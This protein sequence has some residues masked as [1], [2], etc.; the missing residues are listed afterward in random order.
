MKIL[1]L[2]ILLGLNNCGS[3]SDCVEIHPNGIQKRNYSEDEN[4]FHE[5]HSKKQKP[6]NDSHESATLNSNV[7]E[8]KV[9]NKLISELLATLIYY[10]SGIDQL[11]RVFVSTVKE[12]KFGI[13]S[14]KQTVLIPV[15]KRSP[16][17][18]LTLIVVATEI[19][20]NREEMLKCEYEISRSREEIKLSKKPKKTF[21]NKYKIET[22]SENC[23]FCRSKLFVAAKNVSYKSIILQ[24]KRIIGQ[25]SIEHPNALMILSMFQSIFELKDFYN[26]NLKTNFHKY[27][28]QPPKFD[29]KLKVY[30]LDYCLDQDHESYF[31]YW[32]FDWIFYFV[33]RNAANEPL[34][35]NLSSL[36]PN[37]PVVKTMILIYSAIV[38]ET[39]ITGKLDDET[40]LSNW[41]NSLSTL[42]SQHTPNDAI[43]TMIEELYKSFSDFKALDL[44]NNRSRKTKNFLAGQKQKAITKFEPIVSKFIAELYKICE[45]SYN[46]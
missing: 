13:G 24:L 42:I 43:S 2:I 17:C 12:N 14:H 40:F 31:V 34:T 44:N 33:M 22:L 5:V 6:T 19:L 32:V 46:Q 1:N 11:F 16:T 29:S 4:S 27:L 3:S 28:I 15:T 21:E 20:S 37:G 41:K 30:C 39:E 8:V 18:F 35:I 9:L 25:R 26:A 10:R 45:N 7:E 23:D 36:S 38:N